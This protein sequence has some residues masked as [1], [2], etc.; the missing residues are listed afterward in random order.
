MVRVIETNR[1]RRWGL[2]LLGLLLG[3]ILAVVIV[4]PALTSE[5]GQP[6]K[7][8]KDRGDVGRDMALSAGCDM[9]Q[10]EVAME[11]TIYDYL[12]GAGVATLEEG[13]GWSPP[14]LG[15]RRNAFHKRRAGGS[16]SRR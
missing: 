10:N 13:R 1:S 12:L 15:P 2:S 8:Q 9:F 11:E 4:G 7:S 16:G 5:S 14:G 6:S 3:V